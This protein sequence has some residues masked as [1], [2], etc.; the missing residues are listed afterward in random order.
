MRQNT[1]VTIHDL[2]QLRTEVTRALENGL[3]EEA[4][5]TEAVVF[6]RREFLRDIKRELT[7]DHRN[8][9]LIGLPG[10]GKSTLAIVFRDAPV[11]GYRVWFDQLR[12]MSAPD[13]RADITG[14]TTNDL[15][16]LANSALGHAASDKTLPQLIDLLGDQLSDGLPT[17]IVLDNV[18]PAHIDSLKPLY[19]RLSSFTNASFLITS[20]FREVPELLAVGSR[21]IVARPVPALQERDGLQLLTWLVAEQIGKSSAAARPDLNLLRDALE[22]LAR[23]ADGYPAMLEILAGLV[24]RQGHS[25]QAL[26]RCAEDIELEL[27]EVREGLERSLGPGEELHASVKYGAELERLLGNWLKPDGLPGPSRDLLGLCTIL[28]PMPFSYSESMLQLHWKAAC[29]A[30]IKGWGASRDQVPTLYDL[31]GPEHA[32]E[33]AVRLQVAALRAKQLLQDG[34]QPVGR[35][36]RCDDADDAPQQRYALHTI[37]A[38]Y[39]RD[40]LLDSSA[41]TQLH[42]AAEEALREVLE[43]GPLLNMSGM[44]AIEGTRWQGRVSLWL[45]HLAH[46]AR[47]QPVGARTRMASLFL[48]AFWWWG[49]YERFPFCDLLISNWERVVVPPELAGD[50]LSFVDHLHTLNRRYPRGWR[51]AGSDMRPVK[52]AV[53][54]IATLIGVDAG[55]PPETYDEDEDRLHLQGLLCTFLGDCAFYQPARRPLPEA[56]FAAALRWYQSALASFIHRREKFGSYVDEWNEAW[57]LFEIADLHASAGKLAEAEEFCRQAETLERDRIERARGREEEDDVLEELFGNVA[58]VRADIAQSRGDLAEE[59]RQR[60]LAVVHAYAFQV[61]PPQAV[62]CENDPQRYEGGPDPYTDF[63]YREMSDRAA[64]RIADLIAA[65]ELD[66]A[67]EMARQLAACWQRQDLGET[68]DVLRQVAGSPPGPRPEALRHALF[69]PPFDAQHGDLDGYIEDGLQ[70]AADAEQTM[71]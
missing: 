48:D 67:G 61:R 49:Y 62:P 53:T 27:A 29:A 41:R 33:H 51:K 7:T 47:V 28:P 57:M 36:S 46:I 38:D 70:L 5:G 9:A 56:D 17:I 43:E 50:H 25:I 40:R 24:V 55:A 35:E 45:Y 66:A 13:A 44:Y 14:L 19:A 8:L 64:F 30:F 37:A 32:R 11:Q 10:I 18:W 23:Q 54:G 26:R 3:R 60:A 31:E 21:A 65:G 16:G 71:P 69:P 34:D 52:A 4:W 1:T 15:A 6:G 68:A 12:D 2:E 63:F 58:R 42:V 39:F 20:R 59:S 22:S